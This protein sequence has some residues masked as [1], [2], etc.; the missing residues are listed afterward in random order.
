MKNSKDR[1]VQKTVI[2]ARLLSHIT[3]DMVQEMIEN[4]GEFTTAEEI[5]MTLDDG[6]DDLLGLW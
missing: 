1:Y 3:S 2:I 4:V 6:V 5:L